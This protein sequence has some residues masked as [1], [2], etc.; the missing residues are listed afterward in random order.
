MTDQDLTLAITVDRTPEAVFAAL[1]D[2]RSWWTGAIEGDADRVGAEFTYRHEALH[3]SRQRVTELVPGKRVVWHV[4]EG[5]L[6]FASNPNEWTGT[7]IVFDI[8]P[9]GART[10]VRLTHV[11]LRPAC[12]CY[13]ACSRGWS[14]FFGGNFPR[15]LETGQAQPSPF[16]KA[17]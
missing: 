3:R 15:F 16:A 1:N 13:G 8:V 6:S 11:G 2:V 7:D 9:R 4:V 5:H 17:G 14:A 10:E 12:D